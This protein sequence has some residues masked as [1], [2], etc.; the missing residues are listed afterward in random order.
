MTMGFKRDKNPQQGYLRGGS[1]APCRKI[2]RRVK[3]TFSMKEILVSK[4]HGHF[5]P[6]S[7]CFATSCL[8]VT[9]REPWWTNRE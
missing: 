4:I 2:L 7:S 9:A 8:L 1:K 3:D 5:A 6:S